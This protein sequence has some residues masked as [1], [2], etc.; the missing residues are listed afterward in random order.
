MWLCVV[1]YKFTNVSEQITASIYRRK[2]Q[3]R[4]YNASWLLTGL[5]VRPLK[6]EA[7]LH[8]VTSHGHHR[9]NSSHTLSQLFADS[10]ICMRG[11]HALETFT[12]KCLYRRRNTH[13]HTQRCVCKFS[14]FHIKN[15]SL[16]KNSDTKNFTGKRVQCFFFRGRLA[17]RF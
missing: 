1:W 16:T 13:T 3:A 4:T 9:D 15:F 11:R 6:I 7:A 12:Y 14:P 5:N 10:T 2:E 17:P 8:G